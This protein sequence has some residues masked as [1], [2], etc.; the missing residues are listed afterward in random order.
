M[1]T[2]SVKEMRQCRL[3]LS[4]F[5]AAVVDHLKAVQD[6]SMVFL[7]EKPVVSSL[8]LMSVCL[9]DGVPWPMMVTS[10]LPADLTSQF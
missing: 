5:L 9:Q 10:V 1:L 3:W 7:L 4:T 6:P 2:F 8:T